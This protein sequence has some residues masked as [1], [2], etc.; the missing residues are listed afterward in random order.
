MVGSAVAYLGMILA[1]V[2][3]ALVVRPIRRLRMTRPQAAGVTTA[4]ALL[5]A[6]AL[7][8]PATESRVRRAASRL[9]EFAPV[10]QFGEFHSISI[11]A[12]PERVFEA[13]ER[14]RAD[15]IFLFRTLTWIRRGGRPLPG[16][17]LDAGNRE[18][19]IDVALRGGFVRLAS[20]YPR[21]LVIGA[22]VVAPTG[23]PGT[24]TPEMFRTPQPAGYALA[25]MNFLV[26]PDRTGGS[27]LSTETRVYANSPAA[28]RRFAAYWRLIYP[29]SA[30]IRR[31]W[32]RAIRQRAASPG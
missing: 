28:R 16:S 19:L 11:A 22:V 12:R 24:A 18:P 8:F 3:F 25:S 21:E 32:L 30:T 7:S 6:L 26:R 9:D 4:G 2:G 17:I 31:M 10:W 1:G 23:A 15:E 27:I 20:D 14:V 13:I 5:A 29:G